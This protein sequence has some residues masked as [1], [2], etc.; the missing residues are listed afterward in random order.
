M[1]VFY[2]QLYYL[3]TESLWIIRFFPSIWPPTEQIAILSYLE[4]CGGCDKWRHYWTFAFKEL[5]KIPHLPESPMKFITLTL[6][7]PL[8][9]FLSWHGQTNQ[10]HKSVF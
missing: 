6:Y 10:Q 3:T 2:I 4:R 1:R 9:W 7:N 8:H 5:I